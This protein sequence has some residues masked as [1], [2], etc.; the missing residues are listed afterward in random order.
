MSFDLNV[1]TSTFDIQ[2]PYVNQLVGRPVIRPQLFRLGLTSL[3][4][5]INHAGAHFRASHPGGNYAKFPQKYPKTLQDWCIS[6]NSVAERSR[7]GTGDQRLTKFQCLRWRKL[8][9][10]FPMKY[11]FWICVAF[12]RMDKRLRH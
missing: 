8:R 10:D 6:I 5:H 1:V 2:E 4:V 9:V 11:E 3:Y 7:T 12:V